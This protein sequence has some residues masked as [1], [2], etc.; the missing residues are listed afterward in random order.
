[1]RTP[2]PGETIAMG[3]NGKDRGFVKQRKKGKGIK[4]E[5]SSEAVGRT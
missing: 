4:S 5:K 3:G 1:L 2:N